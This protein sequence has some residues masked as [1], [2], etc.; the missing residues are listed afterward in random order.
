MPAG[1]NRER[2]EATQLTIP[3]FIRLSKK[4]ERTPEDAIRMAHMQYGDAFG[5]QVKE[6]IAKGAYRPSSKSVF[7]EVEKYRKQRFR[8][9][10]IK[11]LVI[12]DKERH[13][14]GAIHALI[15]DLDSGRRP[16]AL[17]AAE[18]PELNDEQTS[19]LAYRTAIKSESVRAA[20][21][22]QSGSTF[23]Q[24]VLQ[25]AGLTGIVVSDHRSLSK[26]ARVLANVHLSLCRRAE[27]L[28]AAVAVDSSDLAV[29]RERLQAAGMGSNKRGAWHIQALTLR[30]Q[31]LT[32]NQIARLVGKTVNAVEKVIRVKAGAL[33]DNV[34]DSHQLQTF[35]GCLAYGSS[36]S[37]R[38]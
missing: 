8:E 15:V 26:L 35:G 12:R 37:L 38:D 9:A 27:D 20:V 17:S 36:L 25:D 6:A 23:V 33:A 29:K 4:A 22:L 32:V 13:I 1:S 24:G 21:D 5:V 2:M 3:E 28:A 7:A 30:E 31:G 11:A 18:Q 19:K 34:A 10:G 16:S 14:Q